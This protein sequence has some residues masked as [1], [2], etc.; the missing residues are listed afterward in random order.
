MKPIRG[1]GRIYYTIDL[2]NWR[3]RDGTFGVGGSVPSTQ[4]YLTHVNATVNLHAR[5]IWM[6]NKE[7]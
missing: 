3:H 5:L 4:G 2:N 6:W 7:A 1:A